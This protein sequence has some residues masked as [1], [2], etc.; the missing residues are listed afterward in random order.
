MTTSRRDHERTLALIVAAGLIL[1][2]PV[3]LAD[4][5]HAQDLDDL[6]FAATEVG[7]SLLAGTHGRFLE[8]SDRAV[9]IP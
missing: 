9:R 6:A 1:L 4:E 3:V 8:G 7:G 5:D 2:A